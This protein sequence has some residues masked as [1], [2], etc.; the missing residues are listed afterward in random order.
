[1]NSTVHSYHTSH[2]F[3]NKVYYK[4]ILA[5]LI[6]KV[7]KNGCGHMV[8]MDTLEENDGPQIVLKSVDKEKGGMDKER[9]A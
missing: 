3:F 9:M 7:F 4:Y 1:M 5:S 8:S 6:I 2:T